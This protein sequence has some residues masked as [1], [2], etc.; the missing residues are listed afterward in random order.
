VKNKNELPIE[1]LIKLTQY[2]SREG[3]L[4]ADFFL[5]GF[6]TAKVAIGLK[7]KIIGFEINPTSF[8]YHIEE[9][10]K[11]KPGY[12]LPLVKSGKNDYPHNRGK[13]WHQSEISKLRQ[14][15]LQ[16]Y[17]QLKNKKQTIHILQR[18]FGRGY[19]AILNQLHKTSG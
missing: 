13:P 7:R 9:I 3:D 10:R 8:D 11:V 4:I 5:G 16:V 12:L 15:Y 19:F 14:R 6:S 18:E 2:S 1:L 17:A